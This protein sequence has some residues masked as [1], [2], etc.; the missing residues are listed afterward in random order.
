MGYGIAIAIIIEWWRRR[1]DRFKDPSAS[2]ITDFVRE[3]LM[4]PS[5]LSLSPDARYE[6]FLKRFNRQWRDKFGSDSPHRLITIQNLVALYRSQRRYYEARGWQRLALDILQFNKIED[7]RLPE[8]YRALAELELHMGRFRESAQH[9]RQAIKLFRHLQN[10]SAVVENLTDLFEVFAAHSMFEEAVDVSEEL[11]AMLEVA[12]GVTSPQVEKHLS[13]IDTTIDK[14]YISAARHEHRRLLTA[15]HITEEAL[16]EDHYVVS[17][18]L[19]RL[20]KFF[21]SCGRRCDAEALLKRAEMIATLHRVAGA[22]YR[23]IEKDLKLV[24][25][26]L[27]ERNKSADR[28]VAFH[29]RKRAERIAEKKSKQGKL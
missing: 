12:Y 13:R 18:D 25:D 11:I 14:N 15:L 23:G 7:Q 10:D 9:Y 17:G 27:E 5:E 8:A 22:E 4:P 28:T 24:A 26:W 19:K 3:E 1:K 29:L 20:A 6:R 16:G 21:A 2:W